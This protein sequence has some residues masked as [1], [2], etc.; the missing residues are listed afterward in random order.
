MPRAGGDGGRA[1]PRR[2]PVGG[3]PRADLAHPQDPGAAGPPE[4]THPQEKRQ[5]DV[6]GGSSMAP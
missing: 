6:E 2:G 4:R 3:E 5:G 1:A